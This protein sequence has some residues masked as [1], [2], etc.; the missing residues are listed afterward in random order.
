MVYHPD[1]P[2]FP[3]GVAAGVIRKILCLKTPP[4]LPPLRAGSG[5]LSPVNP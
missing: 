5:L 4:S 3:A 2:C 1:I